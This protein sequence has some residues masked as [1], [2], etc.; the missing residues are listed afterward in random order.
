LGENIKRICIDTKGFNMNKTIIRLTALAL[1]LASMGVSAFAQS[2]ESDF[3]TEAYGDGVRITK[4]VGWDTAIKIPATIGGKPVTAIGQG[5]FAKMNLTS[6]TI[7]DSVKVIEGAS[8]SYG[9]QYG[10]GAFAGNKL[11]AVTL[12][13][14]LE[15]IGVRAFYDN[16]LSA[17]TIPAGVTFIGEWAFSYNTLAKITVSGSTVMEEYAFAR[18]KQ[19]TGVTLG[20][21]CTF[22]WTTFIEEDDPYK[23][24]ATKNIGLRGANLQYD[25]YCNDKKAGTYTV[26]LK[27]RAPKKDGDF[28]YVATR[29]GAALTGYTGSATAVRLPE[30]AGGL[31]VKAVMGGCTGNDWGVEHSDSVSGKMDRVLIP[32]TVTVIGEN[33][34][35]EK[36]LTNI[37]FGTK[38][39]YIGDWA[40]GNNNYSSDSNNKLTSVVLP[41]S[42]TYIGANA[43]FN[44]T[45][46]TSIVIPDSVTYIGDRA[47]ENNSLTSVVI[48]DSVTSIGKSAFSDNELTSVTIGANVPVED[49]GLTCAD[50]Y[51]NNG[52]KAGVYTRSDTNWRSSWT[53]TA[54]E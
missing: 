28:E 46:L 27:Y 49:S 31:S 17:V 9:Q 19:L 41:N 25:Y 3:E 34:F 2:A 37:T 18:N 52:K 26:D 10:E 11:T 30:K 23:L 16:S 45:Y 13:K 32:N 24:A 22:D 54:R 5:A 50:A 39:M 35:K 15:S 7:P 33:A 44:N 21:N 36:G 40:F 12:P 47:F 14:S 29:Y 6:V 43:F 51:D 4:Y 48:P 38:V 53:F 20:T 1:V 8:F 42:V